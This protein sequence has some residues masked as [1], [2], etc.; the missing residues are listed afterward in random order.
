[1]CKTAAALQ[2]PSPA[3]QWRGWCCSGV[4]RSVLQHIQS[5]LLMITLLTRQVEGVV[6]GAEIARWRA[7]WS[8]AAEAQFAAA[9]HGKFKESAA[10]FLNSSWQ[11]D[12]LAVSS[13]RG[14]CWRVHVAALHRTHL[15][16]HTT[17]SLVNSLLASGVSHPLSLSHTWHRHATCQGH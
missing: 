11:G 6:S 10:Q 14:V 2:L 12:A 4:V 9:G 3:L 8:A 7:S 5:I 17:H 1:M 13:C 15:G 16:A